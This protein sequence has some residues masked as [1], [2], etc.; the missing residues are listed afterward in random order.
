MPGRDR[1]N[2]MRRIAWA[3]MI[4]GVVLLLYVVLRLCN[5]LASADWLVALAAI[6]GLLCVQWQQAL[7]LGQQLGGQD[8]A[9]KE[10]TRRVDKIE[11]RLEMG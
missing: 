11:S 8:R 5:L 4:L 2:V 6:A 9:I 7:A 10:L 1:V 3:Y